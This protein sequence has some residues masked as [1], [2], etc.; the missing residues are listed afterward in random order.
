MSAARRPPLKILRHALEAALMWTLYHLIRLLPLDVASAIGACIATNVG[1]L[2]RPHNTILTNLRIA[3]PEHSGNAHEDIARQAWENIGRVVFEFPFVNTSEMSK[4]IEIIGVEHVEQ[5]KETGRP[6]VF[7]SGHFA[8]WELA[9]KTAFLVGV[10]LILIY[11]ASNNPWTDK[12]IH[13]VRGDFY[14]GLYAKGASAAIHVVK[15]LKKKKSVGMLIDQ[16]MNDGI[17][18]PLFGQKAMTAP[19]LIEFAQRYGAIVIPSRVVRKNGAHF[20]TI[21]EPPMEFEFT[22][23]TDRDFENGMLKVNQT[24][25][26]W[27]REYPSQWFWVHKRFDKSLY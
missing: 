22:S 13:R 12:L 1:P 7:I 10:P 5:A 18:V 15:A 21:I 20:K 26:R 24:I 27:V 4:R 11:R 19:A 16:K 23:D 9:A 3:F 25:E 17:P 14:A 8:N 6:I 2:L